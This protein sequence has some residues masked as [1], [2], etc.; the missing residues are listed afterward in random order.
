[1]VAVV[2]LLLHMQLLPTMS[3]DSP[4]NRWLATGQMIRVMIREGTFTMDCVDVA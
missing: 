2:L 3:C 1:M 4:L